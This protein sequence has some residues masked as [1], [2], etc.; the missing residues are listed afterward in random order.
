MFKVF[1]VDDEELILR[2]LVSI[3][4]K[5]E[6]SSSKLIKKETVYV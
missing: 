5:S 2:Y 1:L 4:Y 3:L 6:E